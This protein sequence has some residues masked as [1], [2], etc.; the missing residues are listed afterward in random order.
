MICTFEPDRRVSGKS[1]QQVLS[2]AGYGEANII[3]PSGLVDPLGDS[4][5]STNTTGKG[6]ANFKKRANCAGG[7]G[8]EETKARGRERQFAV[9]GFSNR[10]LSSFENT[11][12]RLRQA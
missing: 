1:W 9:G 12:S 10:K 6:S 8:V 4:S 5:S 11:T 2:K 3:G 7:S